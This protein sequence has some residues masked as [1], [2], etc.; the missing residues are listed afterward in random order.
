MNLVLFEPFEINHPLPLADPRSQHLL[1]TL[2]RAPGDPFEVGIVN[3]PKGT[4]A[5]ARQDP[6]GLHLD[7]HW[8]VSAPT[9][10]TT[11]LIVALP[12]PQTARDI[13]RDATT[14]GVATIDFVATARADP[15][16]AA[17]KLWSSGEW[18]RHVI[19]GAAQA[20]DTAIPDVTWSHTLDSALSASPATATRLAFDLYETEGRL[21]RESLLPPTNALVVVIGPERG[22][23]HVDREIL[24]RHGC[25]LLQLGPRVLR[26]ETAVVAALTLTGA[27]KPSA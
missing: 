11:R 6:S 18:R 7:Y 27:L 21:N 10:P 4:A 12:R 24:R 3:G 5:I 15:N 2:R 22:W 13:L 20:C 26:T 23:D 14:L 1:N 16:Y 9:R 19:T 17:S 8:N 25:R